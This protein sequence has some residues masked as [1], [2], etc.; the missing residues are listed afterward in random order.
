[1]RIDRR[2]GKIFAWIHAGLLVLVLLFPLYQRVADVFAQY[3]TGCLLHDKLFLYCPLCGGTRAVDALLHF[4]FISAL[5]YNAFV[6][7]VLL[8][9][10]S[11]D[12]WALLR[13]LRG[14]KLPLP[15][16]GWFWIVLAAVM[17]V[18]MV[19]RNYLMIAHGYDPCGDLGL[20]WQYLK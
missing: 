1:M 11:L 4:D 17:I 8:L 3:V 18:Y 20:F 2:S 19:L 16:A 5:R 15:L 10:L 13:L 9:A 7:L 14:K 6:V 12:V